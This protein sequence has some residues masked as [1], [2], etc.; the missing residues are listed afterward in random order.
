M[1]AHALSAPTR[2]SWSDG[3]CIA[4]VVIIWGLNFVV[5]KWGL[6]GL[7]P[8]LL[9]AL[10]FTVASLPFLLF[11]RRPAVSWKYVVA[12]GLVQAIGQFG[13][14]FTAL[15]YGM[16]A[17]VAS[18]V[19]QTQALFTLLLAVPLLGERGAP[20]QWLGLGIAAAGLVA[21]ASAHGEGPGQMTLVGFL[22]TLGA[23]FMW[24]VSNLVVRL[25]G[26]T[27]ARY[28]P[29]AF[30]VWS[31]AVSLPPFYGLAVAVDGADATV[32]GLLGISWQ[33][34]LAVLFLGLLATL[35]AYT[36]WTRLLQRHSAGRVSPFSLLVPVVG[37]WAAAVAFDE[38]LQPVQWLGVA[39]ILLG[40]ATNQLAVRRQ[41]RRY[42]LQTAR[43]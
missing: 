23:A 21:I 40:L 43:R 9:G 26:N 36:L 11:V 15:A 32:A 10:R 41:M 14:L 8:M 38:R 4:G 35:L 16:T 17:G 28:D 25:A 34:G 24:A 3:L 39:G 12:Y 20:A 27:G 5:M 6:R 37:L 33:E 30:I 1:S 2:M 13:L 18:V 42:R 19:M 31:S 29:L 7:S 22:L